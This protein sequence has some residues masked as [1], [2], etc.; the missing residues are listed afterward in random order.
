MLVNRIGDAIEIAKKL[1]TTICF[2]GDRGVGKTVGVQ[3]YAK[4]LDAKLITIRVGR[5]DD[6]GELQGMPLIVN[7]DG[8]S[9]T[10]YAPLEILNIDP[11]RKTVIFFDEINRCKPA[12]VN[13]LFEMLEN[14]WKGHV[15]IVA[16]ANPPTDDYSVLDFTDQAFADRLLFVRVDNTPESFATYMRDKN[17]V[18]ADF[19]IKNPTLATVELNEW[20]IEDYIKPSF[21]SWEKV[22]HYTK[23]K[24]KLTDLEVEVLQGLVGI[25]GI[26]KFDNYLVNNNQPTLADV[27]AGRDVATDDPSLVD[28]ILN[29]TYTYMKGN[30]FEA[31]ETLNCYKFLNKLRTVNPDQLIG[32]F[33]SWVSNDAAIND[34]SNEF[35]EFYETF[36]EATEERFDEY[37]ERINREYV[38]AGQNAVFPVLVNGKDLINLSGDFRKEV[39]AKF[40][41]LDKE[42]K[43]LT[44]FISDEKYDLESI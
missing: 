13:G 7:Q 18:L 43:P 1:D 29:E 9:V 24:K 30:Q 2:V 39:L 37:I 34:M 41:E 11:T 19:I 8:R 44:D 27:L 5:L 32:Y 4:K 36:Q 12:I 22:G 15:Q 25:Q 20:N 16:A 17:S 42:L 38:E 28:A 6:P 33:K 10:T 26:T 31:N 14:P 23:D 40:Q 35:L 21:R 3:S